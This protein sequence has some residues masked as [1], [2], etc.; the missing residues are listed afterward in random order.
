VYADLRPGGRTA[1]TID[2]AIGQ[3]VDTA[4]RADTDGQGYVQETR[5]TWELLRPGGAP[6][7][8]GDSLCLAIEATWGDATSSDKPAERVVDLLNPKRPEREAIWTNP[9]AWGTL[10]FVAAGKLDPDRTAVIWPQLVERHAAWQKRVAAKPELARH[11]VD[12]PCL[13][14]SKDVCR[15]LNAWFAEGTAAGNVGDYYD[16]RDHN[17]SPLDLR[18]YPQLTLLEYVPEQIRTQQ[19]YGLFL[20]VRTQVTVG[21][22][23]T[24]SRL[25]ASGSSISAFTGPLPARLTLGN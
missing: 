22:S 11:P 7:Q 17:H 10:E 14:S 9:A 6:Y 24:A 2:Q 20:G 3:G 21:N 4:F 15:L 12:R 13:N 8:A 25:A 1:K 16:N 5:L 18:H 19:D 23:S